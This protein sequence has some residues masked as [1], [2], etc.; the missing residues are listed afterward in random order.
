MTKTNKANMPGHHVSMQDTL[1][2]ERWKEAPQVLFTLKQDQMWWKSQMHT[3]CTCQKCEEASRPKAQDAGV[4]TRAAGACNAA[5]LVKQTNKHPYIK[6]VCKL[7][8][9]PVLLLHHLYEG[10]VCFS[11]VYFTYWSTLLCD[12]FFTYLSWEIFLTLMWP[13]FWSCSSDITYLIL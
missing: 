6:G 3:A 10:L 13:I 4:S 12:L 9:L 8:A 11:A 7:F 2:P 5:A 1:H